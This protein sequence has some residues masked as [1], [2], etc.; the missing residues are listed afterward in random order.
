MMMAMRNFNSLRTRLIIVLLLVVVLPTI[1][2][3]WMA[4]DLMYE[5]IRSDRI[6]DVGRVANVKHEQLT[7]VLTRANNRAKH[8]LS[9]LSKQCG[10][11]F[12]KL[13]HI[14]ATGL[15][16]A[17][18]AAE[19][20]IGADLHKKGGGDSLTIGLPAVQ[21]EKSGAFQT[22]Q[23]A[24][25]SGTGPD[26]NRSYFVS[27]T[28]R[29]T[30]LQLSVTYPSS[31]LE[32]IFNSPPENL[33]LSGET[34]LADGEGY[35][36]TKPKYRSTQGQSHPIHTR[37][38]QACLSGQAREA[39]DLDYRGIE[40]I[41]GFRF[42]PEFGSACIMAHVDQDE[43]FAPLNLLRQRLVFAISLFSAL[44]II[45]IIVLTR[46]IVKPITDLTKVTRA[47]AAGDYKARADV[48]GSDE[49]IELAASFNFMTSQLQVAQQREADALHELQAMLNTSGEGFWKVDPSGCI[50][51]V[52]D[53]YCRIAGYAR[54]EIIGAHISKFEALEQTPEAVAAHIH[55]VREHGYDRFETKHRHH[56]GRLIDIEVIASYIPKTNSLIVFL[57]DATERRQ[58]EVLMQQFGSLLQGSFNEIYLF[59][60][61]SM[62]F[63][64]TSE[65]AERNLGY[66]ADELNQ[67]TPLDIKPLFTQESFER[68]ITPLRNGEPPSLF[69]ETVQRRKDGTTYP[70]EVRLQFM[71][72]EHPA[73]LAIVQ[74]VTERKQAERWMY[75]SMEKIEDLYNNAPCG[76]HSLDKDGII[77]MVND[78]ELT[79]LGYTRDEVAGKIK[80]TDLLTPASRQTFEKT[81]PQFMQQGLV[82]D[83]ELEL[84]RKDGTMLVGLVSATA[85]Y[86]PSGNF[87]MSRST[88]TD[89]T[90]RKRVEQQLRDLAAHLQSVREEEKAS[91][92][93]EIHD[94]LGG[95]LTALK[96]ETHQLKAGLPQDKDMMPLLEHVESISQL[97]SNAASLMRR[98]I[99]DLRP[100]ILDDL[101]LL[102]AIEWQATQFHKHSGIECRVNCIG[103]KGNLDKTRSIA[104]FRILQEALTNVMRHSGASRVEIEFHHSD[105]EVVMS[106]I[107]NGCGMAENR[108]ETLKPKASIPY[109]LLGMSERVDQLGGKISFDTPPG[110]GFN[111]TVILPLPVNKEETT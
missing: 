40:V 76:Y 50:I 110:G 69:F 39:L 15:I 66:S 7:M 20:A 75:E 25:L 94:D 91:I 81:F 72:G 49:I 22:R 77:L 4:H 100:T 78:T 74:D 35:F 97:V 21:D 103:D 51:E 88:V 26:N 104:L 98:I 82:H 46:S 65:G 68:L 12:A 45:T 96:M 106:I 33:G 108:P 58:V 11:N 2:V 17:Y 85:I 28:E 18:L 29:P 5:Y 14:C 38:M 67:L 86:D 52:N 107:D 93:R 59:D 34:F 27:V 8:F 111:V 73:F 6:S 90:G 89:I 42:I 99:S 48:T 109:G 92:A 56:D 83:I 64:L 13:D 31:V 9:S 63:L 62:H 43:A 61:H 3:G 53:A 79:W 36:V 80:L 44:L 37:P 24:K 95:T 101:G 19:G 87:V 47:I 60:A 16:E 84:V 10:G 41:H 23:L 71:G 1:T 105:E 30:G 70:V 55:H 54:D 102:A 32:P 57:H